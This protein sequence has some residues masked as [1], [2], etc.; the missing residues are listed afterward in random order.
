MHIASLLL[1]DEAMLFVLVEEILL[2][3]IV[4][5][6]LLLATND[7]SNDK[8]RRNIFALFMSIQSSLLI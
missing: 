5:L 1:M 7:L 3:M 8:Q 2:L 6:V 4:Y